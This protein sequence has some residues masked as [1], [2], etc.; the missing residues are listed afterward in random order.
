MHDQAGRVIAP[1]VEPAGKV[2]G[3][4]EQRRERLVDAHP[5][6]GEGR[7]DLRPA[8]SAEGVVVEDVDVVVEIDEPVLEHRRERKPR[9]GRQGQGHRYGHSL[10]DRVALGFVFPFPNAPGLAGDRLR[11]CRH[12]GFIPEGEL[13]PRGPPFRTEAVN[14]SPD[15]N[16]RQ[17][18][19]RG[20]GKPVDGH[21]NL[22]G[23]LH[24]FIT[25][26]RYAQATRRDRAENQQTRVG[27]AAAGTR[28][29]S[30]R[31]RVVLG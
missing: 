29:F 23:I 10:R 26:D 1:R 16:S 2:L 8:Q 30:G 21:K 7:D 20:G 13:E 5:R 24:R 28:R 27:R 11:V 6:R 14:A 15:R 18:G 12:G 4:Q 25:P 3:A 19:N 22:T 17:S 9:Q 31:M